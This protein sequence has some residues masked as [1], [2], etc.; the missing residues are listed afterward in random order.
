MKE[1]FLSL[2]ATPLMG[3]AQAVGFAAMAC[4]IICF[5]QKKRK[6]IIIWQIITLVFWVLHFILLRNPTAAAIN[7]TQIARNLVFINREKHSWA[8]K[9]IWP[10]FFIMLTVAIG[11]LTWQ[12]AL[13]IMPIVG[14]S[15]ATVAMWLRKPLHIRLL[16]LPVSVLWCVYDFITKSIAG[17]SNEI[18]TII[19]IIIAIFAVDLKQKSIK[20]GKG[21][22]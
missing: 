5:A 13:S 16:T 22:I 6:N 18:F 19:T 12:N 17:A 11:L 4:A 3:A 2:F 8:S 10:V 9:N 20:T 1:Y 7:T 14:T 15:L 21:E